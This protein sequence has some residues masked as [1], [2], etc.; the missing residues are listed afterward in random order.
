MF[1]LHGYGPLGIAAAGA[2]TATVRD[3]AAAF[4]NPAQLAARK[5]TS[6]AVSLYGIVPN[7]H[8]DRAANA[9]P[10][11]D[12]G[13]ESQ[14]P[15]ANL[16]TSVSASFALGERW[17]RPLAIGV[18]LFVPLLHFTR[19]DAVDPATPQFAI[20]EQLPT[21]LAVVFGAGYE[22][23]DGVRVGL[24]AQVLAALDGRAAFVLDTE[25]RRVVRR[26]VDTSLN[27]ATAPV[28]S[29]AWAPTDLV[30]FGLTWRGAIQ[31][32]YSLPIDILF[33][34]AGTVTIEIDGTALYTPASLTGGVGFH[35]GPW[36]VSAD[37][38]W[39]R[40]SR[41]PPLSAH[42]AATVELPELDPGEE[43]GASALRFVTVDPQPGWR[44][45]LVPRLAASWRSDGPGTPSLTA[46]YAYKPS[47]I[48]EQVGYST[49]LDSNTHQLGLG[50]DLGLGDHRF[51]LST[52]LNIL[53]DRS[54][55]KDPERDAAGVGDVQS[56]GT[57]W[58]VVLGY[59]KLY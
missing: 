28:A 20:H 30:E 22:P 53:A 50:G 39:M 4:Y 23:F 49:Y 48:P 41:T 42:F 46:G 56:G 57:I 2:Q 52:G 18:G 45:T 44:D 55:R 40:W 43:P 24:G 34:D 32:D 7:L 1:E 9:R 13:R 37:L 26:T 29:L 51:R 3:G 5:R 19:L 36:T 54:T 6:V 58:T 33:Q 27:T 31:I 35:E 59:S 11:A 25:G 15:D 17:G 47:P 21:R 14:L 10:E 8:I 12:G 16:G 38:Q